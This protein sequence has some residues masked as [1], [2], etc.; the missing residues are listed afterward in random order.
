VLL[1]AYLLAVL[2]ILLAWPVPVALSRARWTSRSPFAAMVLWQ[3]IA[4]A[5]GLSMI[6]AMLV[7]GLEPLGDNLLQALRRA[8]G[9]VLGNRA[10]DELHFWH[11][12][13]LCAAA[14]LG[15]HLVFTLGL[16]YAR[17]TTQRRRHRELLEVLSLPSGAI[18]R[19]LVINHPA[20][21]AYCLPGGPRS[22]TV[23]S[24]GLLEALSPAELAAVVDHERA[25][26]TQRHHL[27]LWAF[28]AWRQALPWLPTTR[29]SREAVSSLVEML[30]DDIAR[31]TTPDETL[32]RA[33][34]LVALGAGE[35]NGSTGASAV[36][37]PQSGPEPAMPDEGEASLAARVSRLLTP[38]P[39]LGRAKTTAV[40]AASGLL[41]AVPTVLLLAPGFVG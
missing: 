4:L 32:V 2:A 8:L 41:L 15:T 9:I 37:R 26:L 34:A 39:P 29:L 25:H 35:A 23:L 18:E 36:G 1:T 21:V 11:L 24:D 14:L 31:R 38:R 40:L 5:G 30:A 6:G 12:F 3:S 20:P 16:T 10:S 28:E 19:T 27:L 13:A 22:V 7:Y 17:I 33:I